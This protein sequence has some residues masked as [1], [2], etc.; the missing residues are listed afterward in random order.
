[1]VSNCILFN[2]GK[3]NF[4]DP[5]VYS[6]PPQPFRSVFADFNNDGKYDVV[7]ANDNVNKI[8]IFFNNAEIVT[9]V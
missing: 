3:G 2:D 5:L 6:T 4:S 7:A 9:C 8:P 1:M